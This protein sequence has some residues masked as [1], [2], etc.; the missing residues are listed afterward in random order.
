MTVPTN[1]RVAVRQALTPLIDSTPVAPDFDEVRRL[2][3]A[4]SPSSKRHRFEGLG[5]FALAFVV[6]LGL[7]LTVFLLLSGSGNPA[8]N[9]DLT[10]PA[11]VAEDKPPPATAPAGPETTN[12]EVISIPRSGY[13]DMSNQATPVVNTSWDDIEVGENRGGPCCMALGLDGEVLLGDRAE[14]SILRLTDAG[15]PETVVE[16]SG[17]PVAMIVADNG[18]LFVLTSSGTAYSLEVIALDTGAHGQ[19]RTEI[20]LPDRSAISGPIPTLGTPSLTIALGI[21]FAGEPTPEGMRW[22]PLASDSGET[23]PPGG[24]VAQ[25]SLPVSEGLGLTVTATSIALTSGDRTTTWQLPP[26]LTVDMIHPG[27]AGV[28]VAARTAWEPNGVTDNLLLY[29]G[30]DGRYDGRRFEGSRWAEG[31]MWHNRT[32]GK[33][34]GLVDLRTTPDGLE[35]VAYP[36]IPI[37]GPEPVFSSVEAAQIPRTLLREVVYDGITWQISEYGTPDGLCLEVAATD[38]SG[39][40]IADQICSLYQSPSADTFDFASF[41]LVVDDETYVVFT[42]RTG[43]NVAAVRLHIDVVIT[44]E[45]VNGVWVVVTDSELSESALVE[46]LGEDGKVLSGEP[47][48]LLSHHP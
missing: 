9:P 37:T 14:R 39:S 5:A 7:G 20:E 35:V 40:V 30:A 41:E 3:Q 25:S 36:S 15:P 27:P 31:G 47:V 43:A 23:L 1:E 29:L 13:P 10:T 17:V 46:A 12:A 45:V 18:T 34:G 24:Q 33:D 16:L 32:I 8:T 6:V 11:D 22:R 28:H 4:A 38:Q 42:G 19:S 2:A 21:V 48:P 44:D 26:G